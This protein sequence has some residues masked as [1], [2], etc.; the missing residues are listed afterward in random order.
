MVMQF[1]YKAAIVDADDNNQD[2]TQAF[3]SFSVDVADE[4]ILSIA[5]T[6]PG[7]MLCFVVLSTHLYVPIFQLCLFN[8]NSMACHYRCKIWAI[9]ITRYRYRRQPRRHRT[10]CG[11][12]P[13]VAL[14][15]VNGGV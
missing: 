11:S 5:F 6:S 8:R 2:C 1:V 7:R 12:R 4:K 10:F 14:W 15:A 9:I 13:P 3:S